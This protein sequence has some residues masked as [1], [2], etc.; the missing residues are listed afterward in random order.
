MKQGFLETVL[1]WS[2]VI[3]SEALFFKMEVF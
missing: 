3:E 2:R 1:T